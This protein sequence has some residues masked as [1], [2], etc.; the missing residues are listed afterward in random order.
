MRLAIVQNPHTKN[1]KELFQIIERQEREQ[2]ALPE[3]APEFD[4]TGFEALKN[5]MRGNP[6]V[7]VKN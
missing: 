5:A 6:K 7:V 3:K 4:R 2:Q 1:P